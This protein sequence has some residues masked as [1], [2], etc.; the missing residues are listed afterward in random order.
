MNIKTSFQNHQLLWGGGIGVLIVL[1][2]GGSV[3]FLQGTDRDFGSSTQQNTSE[4]APKPA[5]S[6]SDTDEKDPARTL[7][8]PGYKYAIFDGTTKV[9]R[10]TRQEVVVLA[11]IP[12]LDTPLE[13]NLM[14]T[15]QTQ[16]YRTPN[17]RGEPSNVSP[18][19]YTLQTLPISEPVTVRTRSP[20]TPNSR[21]VK[22][23]KIIVHSN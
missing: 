23:E 7:L 2:F 22:A 15:E 5:P 9:V 14:I 10:H 20:I 17:T 12:E 16:M 3:W 18:E 8:P 13:V 11:D 6:V 4:S 1:L 21:S 19:R